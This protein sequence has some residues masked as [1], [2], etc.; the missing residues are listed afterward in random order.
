MN[1]WNIYASI[2]P[3]HCLS[4]PACLPACLLSTEAISYFWPAPHTT[5]VREPRMQLST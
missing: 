2:S 1:I 5:I 3:A 4:V